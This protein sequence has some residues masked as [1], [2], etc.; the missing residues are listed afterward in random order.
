MQNLIWNC[1]KQ[2]T[3]H[4]NGLKECS[5]PPRRPYLRYWKLS[6]EFP[7]LMLASFWPKHHQ[8]KHLCVAATMAVT[9]GSLHFQPLGLGTQKWE[10][11]LG[12]RASGAA[13][14]GLLLGF[15][16]GKI[17]LWTLEI[18]MESFY[19]YFYGRF[20]CLSRLGAYFVLS[21]WGILYYDVKHAWCALLLVL[22]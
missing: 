10:K 20:F 6:F 11:S 22:C 9:A 5:Q 12:S 13:E 2:Q 3:R 19:R 1:R 8:A 7:S 14:V 18:F 17:G 16:L 21:F 4:R 15:G